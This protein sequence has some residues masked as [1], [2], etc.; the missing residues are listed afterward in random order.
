MNQMHIIYECISNSYIFQ[1]MNLHL[2]RVFF[3]VVSHGSFSRGAQ[4]L[5]ISQPAASKAVR[6]LETQLDLPLIE[7]GGSGQRAG[8]GLR[9]TE[10][11]QALYEHARG[12]FALERAAV[13]DL[14]ARAELRRGH[15][16]LGASTTVA[17]YW[18]PAYL[19]RFSR[20]HP[21]VQLHVV[22]GNTQSI[23]RGL[24]DCRVDLAVVEGQV[25]VE[26]IEAMYWRD[27]R[28]V[29]VTPASY[30]LASRPGFSPSDL[31]DEIWLVR[32]EGS[33]TR[34]VTQQLLRANGLE[35]RH[36]IE[37][38]SNEGIARAVAGG[39]GVAMLPWV[40]VQD[41]VSLG[42]VGSLAWT[43]SATL[44]RPLY[45][46]RRAQRPLS[47]AAQAFETL[48]QDNTAALD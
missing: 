7:R 2:T 36:Q 21:A 15:L 14:R 5:S 19:A 32:E 30:A 23:T 26:G 17:A 34:E 42:H 16:T 24:A 1:T 8:K 28:L 45:R 38:G 13:D 12:I 33:G 46:L 18:L 43:G 6:E 41:L 11:G 48:L 25:E 22:V 27:E 40:V 37:I 44:R 31:Q 4:A 9:L 10:S 39:L 20:A 47:P 35:P 29:V 3:E